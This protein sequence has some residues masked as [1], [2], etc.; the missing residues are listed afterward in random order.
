MNKLYSISV[1]IKYM[2]DFNGRTK[3]QMDSAIEILIRHLMLF[4]RGLLIHLS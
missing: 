2:T 3:V 4:G 1:V